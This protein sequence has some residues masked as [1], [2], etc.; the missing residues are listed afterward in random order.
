[1]DKFDI[2]NV[3]K[4]AGLLLSVTEDNRYKARAYFNGAKSLESLTEDLDRVIEEE[5][6]LKIPGIG[7]SLAANI[8]EIH[9]TGELQ[10]LNRLKEELPA[11]VLELSQVPSMTIDRI[12]ALSLA[13]GISSVDELEQ[14]CLNHKVQEVAG[15]GEKT[16][17]SILNGVQAYRKR[18]RKV[19][20]VHA[21]RTVQQL[22]S[23]LKT[24]CGVQEIEVAGE[25]RRW[26]EVVDNIQIVAACTEPARVRQ[27]F[28][29]Y[30]LAKAVMHESSTVSSAILADGTSVQLTVSNCLPA[31]LLIRTG[32]GEHLARVQELAADRGLRLDFDGLFENEKNLQINSEMELYKAIGLAY[33]PPEVRENSGELEYA[34]TGSYDDLIDVSHIRGMTHCHTT[35]SDGKNSIEEMA[36]AAER[37]GMEYL[38]ITDHSPT[39]SYAG[40]VTIERLKRQWAEI[41]RVQAGVRIRLLKGTETD[42]LADGELDYPDHI[43]EKFDIIIASV[44]SRFKLDQES[45]T[46]RLIRC[47]KNSHFKIWGHPLGRLLLRRD[48]IPCHVERVLDAVA[49]S[50]AAIEI[51][52]NP[53][54]LD[55]EP[56]WLIEARKRGIK[57]IVS[58][59]A[60]ST[61]EYSSLRFG[62]HQARR[63]S[64]TREEVLN[65]LPVAQFASTVRPT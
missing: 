41:D 36:L 21:E 50:R 58:T 43:L 53:H 4:E 59:D 44:H 57:F 9:T 31:A 54:R 51:N 61:Q 40:G 52:S 55:L 38:T 37:M 11:G 30:T 35:Y 13:L 39:A 15:F 7:K 48:P 65:T 63:A 42:I 10:M 22:I 23:Y 28:E 3:L 12:K 33:I 49:E 20:L 16:E 25:I 14:A 6:L 5:R 27:A 18:L 24:A 34:A 56:K 29:A 8:I 62:V 46:R 64:I 1:M 2:A 60:H 45:M 19:L 32:S 47:M 17:T 26:H